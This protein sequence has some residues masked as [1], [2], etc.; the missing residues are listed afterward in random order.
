MVL[1]SSDCFV[2]FPPGALCDE[3]I[4]DCMPQPCSNDARCVDGLDHYTCDCTEGY[5]GHLCDVHVNYCQPNPCHNGQCTNIITGYHC[6]CHK[7]WQGDG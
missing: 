2:L 7:G 5:T 4:D 3:D 6:T 1:E